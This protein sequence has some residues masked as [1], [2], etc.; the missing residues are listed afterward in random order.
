MEMSEQ[1]AR[2][3]S[4]GCGADRVL[5]WAGCAVQSGFQAGQ[6]ERRAFPDALRAGI[7]IFARAHPGHRPSALRTYN[8]LTALPESFGQLTALKEL[9]LSER[10]ACAN[11]RRGPSAAAGCERGVE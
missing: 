8:K 6:T 5:R 9:V 1:R 11:V 7:C 3:P 10:S 2:R 4:H